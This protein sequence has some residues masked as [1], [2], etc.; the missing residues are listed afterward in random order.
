MRT[1]TSRQYQAFSE[2]RKIGQR[3]RVL[4]K[5]KKEL[6]EKC[7]STFGKARV[8]KTT[9]GSIL[10]LEEK[11]VEKRITTIEAYSYLV[12]KET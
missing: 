3:M 5:E 11:R 10:S 8:L 9:H 7:L 2:H 6:K 12:I 4:E 1:I